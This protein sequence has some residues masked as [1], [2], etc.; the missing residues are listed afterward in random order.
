[1]PCIMGD[2]RSCT[3]YLYVLA[4]DAPF[5]FNVLRV[6]DWRSDY[7][8]LLFVRFVLILSCHFTC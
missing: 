8:I 2:S 7:D 4:F 3:K 5:L 6:E 1:M